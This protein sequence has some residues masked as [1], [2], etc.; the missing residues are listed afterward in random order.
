M[1]REATKAVDA[2]QRLVD[3]CD[4]LGELVATGYDTYVTDVRTQWAVEMGLIRLG[5][6][7]SRIPESIRSR[8]PG[9]P[10]RIII[11]LRNIA[12]HQYDSLTT[13][14]V[15]DTLLHD[16]PALRAYAAEVIIPTLRREL[17]PTG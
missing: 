15:W 7:V 10:W 12:A 14:R 3:T 1:N 6:E 16:I 11:D 13:R 4:V 9:Q 8:F 5:E 2:A 17:G